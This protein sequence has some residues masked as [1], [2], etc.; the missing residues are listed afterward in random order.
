MRAHQKL[1]QPGVKTS[2]IPGSLRLQVDLPER[3]QDYTSQAIEVDKTT[4]GWLPADTSFGQRLYHA[5]DG[6]EA[7]VNVVLMGSDRTS[8][9]RDGILP[10]GAGLAH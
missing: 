5:P 7:A 2:P 1:G 10:G 8:L 4:L 3:V 9:H 6:F